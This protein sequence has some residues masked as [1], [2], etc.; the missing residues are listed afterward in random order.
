MSY[1]LH[2]QYY[3]HACILTVFIGMDIFWVWLL[4]MFS[5]ALDLPISL[6]QAYHME[7]HA[8]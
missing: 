7:S 6:R 4:T 1:H 2:V 5:T 8:R 3:D